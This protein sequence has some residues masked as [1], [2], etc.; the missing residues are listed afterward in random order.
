MRRTFKNLLFVALGEFL[1]QLLGFFILAYLARTL[2]VANFGM[3]NFAQALFSYGLLLNY[4]GLPT[5]GTREVARCQPW[6]QRRTGS[7]VSSILS[8]RLF[9]SLLGFILIS[10]ISLTIPK[11]YETKTLVILYGFSLFTTG[12]FLDWF[13]QGMER[14]EYLTISRIINYSAYFLFVV[15]M[16]HRPNDFYFVPIGFFLGNF[17]VVL[18]Q[19]LVYQ[20]TY[21]K[22]R[23]VFN[24]PSGKELLKMA[25]PLGIVSILIQFGQYFTPSLLGFIKG[26]AAVGYF[27]A[28]AKL[29]TMITIIDR[30]FT[31]VALPMITRYYA[32][33]NPMLLQLLLSHLQKLLIALVL[34]IIVGSVILAQD[35]VVLIYGENYLPASSVFRILIFFFGI[36]IFTSLYGVSLIAGQKEKRYA[37]AIGLGT[38]TNVIL[39]PALVILFGP[40][41]SAITVVG[42]EAVTLIIA[43]HYYQ[44]FINSI[45]LTK[46]WGFQSGYA[47]KPLFATCL[48]ALFPLLFPNINIWLKIFGCIILYF[49][50]LIL[51]KGITKSDLRLGTTTGK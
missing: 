25:L 41:G 47:L 11:S 16:I 12:L 38:L 21:G 48:M 19:L 8:L 7:I 34:P 28:A 17:F 30:V 4:L 9:L 14:M 35:I 5:L 27:S 10:I 32:G 50:I 36:T 26:N 20:S 6:G 31:I 37:Q 24:W 3:I 46:G 51:I 13:Y 18:F 29:V 22:L 44:K 45:G 33:N 43:H 15:I 40:I 2:G 42:S 23:F 49:G 1:G 39:N